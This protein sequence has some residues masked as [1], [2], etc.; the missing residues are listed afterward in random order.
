MK[1][2]FDQEADLLCA[3]W[4]NTEGATAKEVEKGVYL[5]YKDG[6]P[7]AFEVLFLHRRKAFLDGLSVEV[8]Q[9]VGLT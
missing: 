2:K 9:P 4:G 7:V 6:E 3:E 1:I 5:L 8:P